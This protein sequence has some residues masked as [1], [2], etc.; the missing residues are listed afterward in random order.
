M[1]CHCLLIETESGLVLVD[2]GLGLEDVRQGGAR[3]GRAFNFVSRPRLDESECALRQVEALGYSAADVRHIIV[4]HLDLDHAGGLPD[5]P[6]ARVHI[7]GAEHRAG[8]GSGKARYV[9]AQFSGVDDWAVYDEL[10]EPWHGFASVR[11][12]V[13]LPPEILLVPLVG[14]SAG[15][16]GVAV[17][18]GDRW[19]LHCGDAYFHRACV[20]PGH[21]TVPRALRAAQAIEEYDGVSRLTNQRRLRALVAEHGDLVDVFC[22]H[23]PMEFEGF[24][25]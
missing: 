14:H 5:F 2:T 3:I 10:G 7:Y 12:L 15:N 25:S 13:G 24:S 8:F 6:N 21:G 1:P 11:Q 17:Q 9:K 18:D 23:D 19:L 20:H 22:S 16:A 4:T